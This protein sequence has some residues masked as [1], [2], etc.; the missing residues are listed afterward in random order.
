MTV[1]II[2]YAWVSSLPGEEIPKTAAQHAVSNMNL[3][4]GLNN[5]HPI[6]INKGIRIDYFEHLTAVKNYFR[7]HG[8][9]TGNDIHIAKYQLVRAFYA[10]REQMELAIS[11][12]DFLFDIRHKEIMTKASYEL[13]FDTEPDGTVTN[14][15]TMHLRVTN[16]NLSDLQHGFETLWIL[17]GRKE[18]HDLI[19][20]V[21]KDPVEAG[22]E[23]I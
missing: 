17:K 7:M 9:V 18:L 8:I 6:Y 16:G 19:Y 1:S 23:E 21:Y 2:V 10:M 4:E 3:P 15:L 11:I 22:P 5:M 13:P 14:I 12:T 20:K